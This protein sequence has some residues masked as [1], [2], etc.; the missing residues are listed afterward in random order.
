MLPGL[1][2]LASTDASGQCITDVA[3][4]A[5]LQGQHLQQLLHAPLLMRQRLLHIA[6]AVTGTI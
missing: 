4:A 1:P 2:D 5:A 3:V 6:C